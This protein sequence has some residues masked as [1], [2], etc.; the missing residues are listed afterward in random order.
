VSELLDPVALRSLLSQVGG[1]KRS[2]R[3]F[4]LDFVSLW[5]TRSQRLMNALTRADVEDAHIV[6]LGIRSSSVML[7]AVGVLGEADAMH[8]AL[9]SGDLDACRGG[10]PRL[11]Q[12]GAAT[13]R[14]LS[15]LADVE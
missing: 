6:L 7:G 15:A 2:H 4:M 9:R 13:C 10:L 5:D 12:T 11:L 14:E 8:A 3:R 1:D